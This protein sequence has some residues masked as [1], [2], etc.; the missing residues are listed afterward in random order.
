[1][2]NDKITLLAPAKLNL[3]FGVTGMRG[4]G[5]HE[6]ETI[7]QTVTVFDRVS[8]CAFHS[9]GMNI[10]VECK[11]LAGV[12]E[13]ENIA[14]RAAEAYL[15]A[16]ET[17][18]ANVNIKIEKKIPYGAGLGGGSSDAAAVILAL[19][20][21]FG[22]KFTLPELF[23]IGASI[24]ADVPFCIKKGTAQA[25]GFGEN[26]VSCAPMPDCNIVIALPDGEKISTAE[27]YAKLEPDG[28]PSEFAG[29]LGAMSSCD[30]AVISEFMKNDFEKIMPDD[31]ASMRIKRI[32]LQ[33][34]AVAAQMSGSGPAV[35][36]LFRTLHEAKEAKALLDEMAS[37]FICTPA[38]RDYAYIEK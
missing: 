33:S 7:M 38:R 5:Y 10:S 36:G 11:G 24:G 19:N 23:G 15:S 37:T 1:M 22:N 32:M 9:D 13:R 20:T 28:Y 14:Y 25:T 34:G 16:A 4:D 18:G 6:V 35:F 17:D 2:E 21:I 12:S 3:Y 27:A 30:L 31:G 29:A 26:L 8:V